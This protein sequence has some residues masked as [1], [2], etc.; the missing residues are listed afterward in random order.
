MSSKPSPPN[1]F[2][3]HAERT[4]HGL[5]PRTPVDWLFLQPAILDQLHDSV[6]VTDLEGNITGCN[7]AACLMFGYMP[8][9]LIGK[10]VNILYPE[11]DQDPTRASVFAAVLEQ[12]QV[13]TEMRNRTKSGAEI[14]IHL[15]LT[16]LRDSDSNPVG[17]LGLSQDITE[18]K[19]AELALRQTDQTLRGLAQVCP[20]FFFTTR[21]DGWTDWVS[22]KFYDHT[23]AEQGG[24]DGL[25][26]TEYLHPEDREKAATRWMAAVKSGNPFETEHRFRGRDGKYRWFRSRAIPIRN[27]KVDVQRWVGIGSDVHLQKETEAA[28]RASENRFKKLAEAIPHSVWIA[29]AEGS[30]E[31]SNQR[32]LSLTGFTMEQSLGTGWLAAIHPE[33]AKMTQLRWQMAVTFHQPFDVEYRVR[34]ASGEYRWQLARAVPGLAEDGK[35]E[36]WFGTCTDIH[37]QKMAMQ[38]LRDREA[39]LRNFYEHSPFC[40][41]ITEFLGNDVLIVYGNP[42][43]CRSY[44][45]NPGAVAGYTIRSLGTADE[46]QAMLR[47]YQQCR[48]TGNPVVTEYLRLIDGEP[49]WQRETIAPLDT[50]PTGN[51]RFT[52][53]T[54]DITR[55]KAAEENLR[56]SEER[57]RTALKNSP[58]V[59]FCQDK[60]LRYTWI[61]NPALG[62]GEEEVLGKRDSD[63]FDIKEE[64]ELLEGLKR[65]VLKTGTGRREEVILQGRGIARAYDLA[66]EP[67]RNCRGEIEGSTCTATDITE[68]REAERELRQQ[69]LI[70]DTLINSTTDYIY[71]KDSEGRYV[72]INSSAASILDRRAK[73]VL[74]KND[75]Y[76]FPADHAREV[77]EKDRELMAG[78]TAE[79]YEETR[80]LNG[81]MVELQTSKNVCR[82]AQGEVIGVVGISRDVTELKR[83]QQALASS[84]L[85]SAGA[86]MA[87]ALAHEI[88]NPLEAITNALFLL[89]H[90][91]SS[92]ISTGDLI[93]ASQEALSRI[94]RITRQM[95][96][97]YQANMEPR[98]FPVHELVEDTL[99]SLE[100]RIRGK[101]LRLE[102]RLEQCK[103][104]GIETDLRRLLAVLLEN[105]LEQSEGI[106][107]VRLYGGSSAVNKEIAGVRLLIANNGPGIPV[108]H[109]Q[110]LF[111]P[112]FSTKSEKASG[113]GLWAARA[114]VNKYG[115]TIRLRSITTP[116]GSGTCVIVRLPSAAASQSTN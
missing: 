34:T 13:S 104:T 80:P 94:A 79:V 72:F 11:Q 81:Q 4:Q 115:G 61:Y 41:G 31:Y 15:T 27:A 43:T 54:K 9:E 82:D 42:S 40:M 23:G 38:A 26:W 55:Y 21:S 33:D 89:R 103:F 51:P 88:N 68:R 17:L 18:H 86:R 53:V 91:N 69:K 93:N 107:K 5:E 100:S 7:A 49:H 2:E 25:N 59:V 90:G 70:L 87:H 76:V 97:L 99:A 84:E 75:F 63:L 50:A 56:K 71:M 3:T 46:V 77:V 102:K 116:T 92:P 64:V 110:R 8:Q 28:L 45:L 14:H 44:G 52:F 113:L 62:Y 57:F 60:D 24:A 32:W 39:T 10:N 78:H 30:A 6:I 37:D 114:I 1:D 95:T 47:A 112:F 85:N 105:A 65:N 58:V 35:T 96:G 16:L 108:E 73:D 74:G 83:V 12:G 19:L 111:E 20:D 101:G 48:D 67:M 98:R 22:Q 109:R 66:I 29:S 106:L 36:K